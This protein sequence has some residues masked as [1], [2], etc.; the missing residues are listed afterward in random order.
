M[1]NSFY[2][3]LLR[4]LELFGVSITLCCVQGYVPATAKKTNNPANVHTFS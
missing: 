2:F 3:Q 4:I 1:F